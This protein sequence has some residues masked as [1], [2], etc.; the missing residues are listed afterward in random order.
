MKG[1]PAIRPAVLPNHPLGRHYLQPFRKKV[2]R[3][4][5]WN[6]APVDEGTRPLIL[7]A[8]FARTR[9]RREGFRR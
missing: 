8:D 4:G 3:Q 9:Q 5:M 1:Q 6:L 7:A 2:R